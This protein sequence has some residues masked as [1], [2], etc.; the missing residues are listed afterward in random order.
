MQ[1]LLYVTA[2]PKG[3]EKSKGLQ[4]GE[5]FLDAFYAERPDV[6]VTRLD[7]FNPCITIPAMDA[8]LVSA[9]GKVGGYGVPIHQLEEDERMKLT[10]MH[11]LADKF[12]SYDYYVFV[13]PVW[14]LGSPAVLKAFLDNLFVHGKTFRFTA[15][16]PIGL[17]SGKKGIHIQ[18]RGGIYSH[19]PMK[20][21]ESGDRYLQIAL[22]FLGIRMLETV[23]AEGLEH[24]PQQIPEIITAAKEKAKIAARDMA[25]HTFHTK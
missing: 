18:T 25:S 17:L 1:K 24:F 14:N 7:L 22:N 5:A 6:V 15:E 21:L 12:N 10:A 19:G 11:A 23:Y 9:R 13:S 20:E 3:L 8:D 2:N 16:G 4:I